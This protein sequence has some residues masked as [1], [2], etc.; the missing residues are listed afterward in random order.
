MDKEAM[1]RAANAIREMLRHMPVSDINVVTSSAQI[2]AQ[3]KLL[4]SYGGQWIN[5]VFTVGG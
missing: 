4:E 1:D 3:A 5:I 2:V